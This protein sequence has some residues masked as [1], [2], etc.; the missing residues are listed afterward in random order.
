MLPARLKAPGKALLQE[1]Q[2]PWG[3]PKVLLL[4]Y[5][6]GAA[7]WL[8]AEGRMQQDVLTWTSA[9]QVVLPVP[10]SSST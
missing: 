2:L 7:R 6:G 4:G 5:L 9:L 3:L 1:P 8:R 10:S